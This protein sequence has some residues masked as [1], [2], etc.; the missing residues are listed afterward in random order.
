MPK[1]WFPRPVQL[2]LDNSLTLYFVAGEQ[3][4]PRNLTNHWWLRANEVMF[5]GPL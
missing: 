5:P 3:D 4:V 1:A 2:L